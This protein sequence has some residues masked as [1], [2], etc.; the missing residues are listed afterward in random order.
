MK[1]IFLAA[2]ALC[3]MAFTITGCKKETV[4]VT[5]P[6][7]SNSR[8]IIIKFPSS[9]YVSGCVNG[10]GICIIWNKA[11]EEWAN[12]TLLTDEG[13]GEAW[14]QNADSRRSQ[15]T[16]YLLENNLS[17]ALYDKMVL[18]KKYTFDVDNYVPAELITK[19]YKDAGITD[20]PKEL[21]IPKGDYPVIVEGTPNAEK[22]IVITVTIKVDVKK[23]TITVTIK[24]TIKP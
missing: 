22:R 16:Y 13:K 19:S 2:I 10:R 11:R 24:V 18:Q 20:V 12:T 7:P 8:G 23:E 6:A 14:A 1:K 15:M 21:R 3:I 4:T 9:Y 5:E 17:P